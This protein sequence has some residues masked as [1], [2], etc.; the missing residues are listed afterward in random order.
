MTAQPGPDDLLTPWPD[1]LLTLEEFDALPEDN[2]RRYELQEGVLIVT[3]RAATLHQRIAGRLL[4]LLNEQLPTGWESLVDVELVTQ[5]GF[6]ARVRV[7]DLVVT[8]VEVVDANVPRLTADQV[9]LA[10][11]II[12]PGSRTTD[13]V[14]KPHEYADSGIPYYWVIDLDPPVSLVAYRLAGDFGYQEAPAVTGKFSTIE[15][16]PLNFDLVELTAPRK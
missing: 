13:T 3:P 6:P 11:E 1:H 4:E 5:A 16:F 8:T 9:Q 10:V 12:S 7:P 14:V 2:S 15:P